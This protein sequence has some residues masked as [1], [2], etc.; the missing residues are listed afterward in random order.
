MPPRLSRIVAWCLALIVGGVVVEV[1]AEPVRF[2]TVVIDAGHRRRC[3]G[4]QQL[5]PAPLERDQATAGVAVAAAEAAT[6]GRR[7]PPQAVQAADRHGCVLGRDCCDDV[8]VFAAAAEIRL[9]GA[10]EVWEG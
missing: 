3:E 10:K 2:S 6:D 7:P 9:E 1:A 8:V 4:P 5:P